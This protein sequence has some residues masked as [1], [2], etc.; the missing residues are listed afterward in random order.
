MSY[1]IEVQN[2]Y[3]QYPGDN[4]QDALRGVSFALKPGEKVALMGAN[5]SGKTTLVRCLNGLFKPTSGEV[6]VD[7]LSTNDPKSLNEIRRRVGMVFQNPDNQ[8]VAATVE[9]EIA[10]GL[11]NLGIPSQIMHERVEK[12]L[13]WFH[14]L[15]YRNYPPHILSGGE[16][17][18]L[19][20]AS[21]WVM[22][23][24]YIVLDEPTSL[25]DPRGRSEIFG[26]IE[27]EKEMKSTSILL[28]TQFPVEVIAFQRLIILDKGRIVF[29]D[30]PETVFQHID[31]LHHMG[32]G[33]PIENEMRS[34]LKGNDA[35]SY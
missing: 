15:E 16:R 29:D 6:R 2:I 32:V 14:L 11:E 19:A 20:L 12:V 8:I 5:G 4:A 24:E 9:R 17:Q 27:Q 18:R 34:L 28:V 22:E 33:V 23:P 31:E 35:H 26:L 25:L 21:V 10:F 30:S 3:F 13:N 1:M 7:G